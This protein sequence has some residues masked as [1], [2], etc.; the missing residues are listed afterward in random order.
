M[1]VAFGSSLFLS[2]FH[3]PSV[4]LPPSP[5][6]PPS[7]FLSPPPPPPPPSLPLSLSLYPYLP[8]SPPPPSPS[9]L[10]LPL[11]LHPLSLSLSLQLVKTTRIENQLHSHL[12]R[13]IRERCRDCYD[14][15][16]HYLRQGHFSCYDNPTT[17]TYRTT[18]INPFPTTN[19]THLVGIIQSWVSTSPPLILDG[20]KVK[21]VPTAP[22]AY[23]V[24]MMMSVL[25]VL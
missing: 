14:F 21:V 18:L 15:S 8:P 19:S 23:P 4:S 17:V 9:P 16:A 25:V 3:H 2:F 11:P 6:L 24:L 13:I 22:H 10:P 1:G 5:S 12:T 7:L 20:L